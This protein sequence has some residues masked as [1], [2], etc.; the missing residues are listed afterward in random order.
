MPCGGIDKYKDVHPGDCFL[1]G[2][3]DATHYCHEW[4]CMLHADCI[5]PF[6][7]TEEGKIVI[8]HG[9]RV[10]IWYEDSTDS[11]VEKV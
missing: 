7:E 2:K 3:P 4:D 11:E 10:T 9:H 1:C 6:L 5:V 8:K